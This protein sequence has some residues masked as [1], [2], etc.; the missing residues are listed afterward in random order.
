MSDLR[1]G[2]LGAARISSNALLRPAAETDGV[3]VAA[4]ASR[5]RER[6]NAQADE[7]S[8]ET[9]HDSYEALLAD[10]TLDAIY[11]PLPTNLHHPWTIAAL[12][13][14]KHVLC[15]KPFASNAALAREMVEAGDR[16]N[17]RDGLILMEAFHWRYH[18][19]ATRLGEII[20]SGTL[21]QIT[22]VAAEF[23]VEIDP[24]DD[25][26][27]AWELSGGALMDLGCYPLQWVR[28]AVG[29]EPTVDSA[30]MVQGRPNVDIETSIELSFPGGVRG[31][32]VTKMSQGTELAFW[33]RV[34]GTDGELFARNPLAPHAGNELVVR[35]ATGETSE[36]VAG[37]T[38]YHYQLEA[39]RDAIRL[40]QPFPTG[41]SDSIAMMELIDA[42]YLAAGMAPRGTQLP[43]DMGAA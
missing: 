18:P 11:N 38:T 26:R 30:T 23:S 41:G 22:D 39:F 37:R 17:E 31:S 35:T 19:F 3:V 27:H 42:C 29:E 2:V 1:I 28:F 25:V 16:A 43:E 33:L 12:E 21:G 40:G 34:V 14:G 32:V 24:E 8:I 7:F 10:P 36:E 15:E 9:V 20:A 4:I 5:D 6:A 13:A